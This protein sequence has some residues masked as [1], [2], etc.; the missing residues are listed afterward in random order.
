MKHH[1]HTH[2]DRGFTL[3][4]LLVVITIIAI[5]ASLAVPAGNVVLRKAREVQAKADLQ[6]LIIAIKGYE[7]EYNR[8]PSG[9]GAAQTTDTEITLED[10]NALLPVLMKPKPGETEN[11]SNPRQIAFFEGKPAKSGSGG[12]TEGRGFVDP[13]SKPGAPHPYRVALDYDGDGSVA[14]PD[15]FSGKPISSGSSNETEPDKLALEVI[16]WSYGYKGTVDGTPDP[17]TALKSWR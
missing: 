17:G 15:A 10:G 16:S 3:I 9:E 2:F 4:E 12:V 6:T 1:H 11:S 7:T 14:T 8:L 13:F 5:L